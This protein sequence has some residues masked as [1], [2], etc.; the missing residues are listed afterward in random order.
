MGRRLTGTVP[1]HQEDGTVAWYG[2]DDDIPA[3]VAARIGDHAWITDDEPEPEP[4][5]DPDVDPAPVP[6]P[7]NGPGSGVEAWAAYAAALSVTVPEG[8]KR[9]EIVEAVR[10][11]GHP[12]EPVN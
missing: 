8:A 3:D 6:P 5:P 10:A 12:V 2:P 11:A 9:D 1:I 4:E 7:L